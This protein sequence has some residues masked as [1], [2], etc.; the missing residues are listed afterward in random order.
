MQRRN[1]A[2]KNND[3]YSVDRNSAKYFAGLQIASTKHKNKFPQ[4]KKAPEDL[5][6]SVK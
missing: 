6:P 1:L 3:K 4:K 5:L 2:K